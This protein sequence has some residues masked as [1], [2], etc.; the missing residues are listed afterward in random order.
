MAELTSNDA[1]ARMAPGIFKYFQGRGLINFRLFPNKPATLF[2]YVQFLCE[3][4]H[5][6]DL[7][8]LCAV[9]AGAGFEVE[10]SCLYEETIWVEVTIQR[11]VPDQKVERG[12]V[13]PFRRR[14]NGS[15]R[16]AEDL[17]ARS[18]G[19]IFSLLR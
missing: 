16:R 13:V 8:V 17:P 4:S 18:G 10:R 15:I 7:D 12:T 2:I 5:S 3:Q 9:A 19:E 14:S 1:I 11:D 6:S